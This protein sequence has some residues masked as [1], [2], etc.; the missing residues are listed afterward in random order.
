M[1]KSKIYAIIS[2]ISALLII[3]T[4][5]ID[6]VLIGL[7][8]KKNYD[9]DLF[10]KLVFLQKVLPGTCLSAEH[11]DYL[12]NKI[13][14]AQIEIK[15]KDD[16]GTAKF[17]LDTW[18][19]MEHDLSQCNSTYYYEMLNYSTTER[20][21]PEK[22]SLHLILLFAISIIFAGLWFK[23]NFRKNTIFYSKSK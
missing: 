2:I 17:V 4:F 21:E 18:G 20:L 23:N 6:T 16:P 3:P 19:M 9:E 14:E 10:D 1:N 12:S 22:S 7:E 8:L 15:L 5:V 11:K 13:L